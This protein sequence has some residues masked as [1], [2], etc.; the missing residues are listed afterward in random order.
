MI[1]FLQQRQGDMVEAALTM[2]LMV[3]LA[4]V[5][6]NFALV[7]QARNA[8]QNAA[9][10]GARMGSIAFTDAD[11]HARENAEAALQHCLCTARV[12]DVQAQD[13]PG[14]EVIVEVEWEVENYFHS[15][16]QYLGGNS[17]PVRFTGTATA[18]YRKE[19][20]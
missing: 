13:T 12:T 9:N 11:R 15:L 6:V 17:L 5:L 18:S 20:W 14:G 4:L 1:S 7:G 16:F 10:F 8:A 3:L 2:P 19:G